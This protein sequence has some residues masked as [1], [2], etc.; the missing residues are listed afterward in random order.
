VIG[1]TEGTIK[2]GFLTS[3]FSVLIKKIGIVIKTSIANL[4]FLEIKK[5][6]IFI[7]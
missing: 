4:L 2:L 7:N 5:D 3:I 6:F 1:I